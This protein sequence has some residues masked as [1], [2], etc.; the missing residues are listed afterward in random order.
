MLQDK[1][2]DVALSWLSFCSISAMRARS[3]QSLRKK[4]GYSSW[5]HAV[6]RLTPVKSRGADIK[7]AHL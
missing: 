6:K 3:D 7:D 4:G 1:D 2:L 5:L